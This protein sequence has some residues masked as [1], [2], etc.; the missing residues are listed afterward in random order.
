MGETKEE[1]TSRIYPSLYQLKTSE[2]DIE[3]LTL[4]NIK[5]EY[6]I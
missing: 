4:K 3:K 1:E 5:V 6:V 2:M